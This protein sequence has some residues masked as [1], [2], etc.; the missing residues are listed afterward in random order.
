MFERSSVLQDCSDGM[1]RISDLM[2]GRIINAVLA[3]PI[4]S[5][6]QDPAQVAVDRE[7]QLLDQMV[8][9]S[10]LRAR[11]WPVLM[12]LFL[13]ACLSSGNF[14]DRLIRGFLLSVVVAVFLRLPEQAVGYA[15]ASRLL[16]SCWPSGEKKRMGELASLHWQVRTKA[17][18]S[19]KGVIPL[20]YAHMRP[21]LSELHHIDAH[22][23]LGINQG[24]L[25]LEYDVFDCIAAS[26]LLVLDLLKSGIHQSYQ[27]ERFS[28]VGDVRFPHS[29]VVVNRH[30]GEAWK[31]SSWNDDAVVLCAWYGV[32]FTASELRSKLNEYPL[33]QPECS[34]VAVIPMGQPLPSPYI[35]AI[36]AFEKLLEE[37]ENN[38]KLA[39][40]K[41]QLLA[42]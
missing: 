6:E 18:R 34:K 32:C 28:R 36:H 21:C 11:Y 35:H 20:F 10:D 3:Q 40:Y 17:E 4:R 5:G 26:S 41:Q 27:V 31:I 19:L 42:V 1:H 23:L 12:V 8:L 7:H 15:P 2:S 16:I 24:L 22:L 29:F 9:T 14:F 38:S 37:R 33:L 30:Q 13:G 39:E 25:A